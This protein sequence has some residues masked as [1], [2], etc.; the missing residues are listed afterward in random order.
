[1]FSTSVNFYSKKKKK[2]YKSKEQCIISQA[3]EKIFIRSTLHV[4]L[5]PREK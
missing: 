2:D 1:L 4:A 5:T 3:C